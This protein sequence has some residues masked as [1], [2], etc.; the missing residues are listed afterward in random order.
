MAGMT[1]GCFARGAMFAAGL[2][3]V[4]GAI[5][6][7]KVTYQ[8]QVLP[9]IDNHCARCHNPD[10]KKG[11]LDLT[12]YNGALKGGGSGQVLVSGSPDSSKL[13]K[14]I[15]HAE[16]PTMPPNKPPLPD[17][18]IDVFKRWI[19]GGLLENSG[20]KAIAANKS[21]V[22][23]TLKAGAVGKPEGPP[24]MPPELP[25]DP[26]VHTTRAS[27]LTG[28]TCSP[29]APL[30]VIGGQKQVL[31][32]N[33]E[34]LELVGILPDNEGTPAYVQ[35]SRNGKL[36]LVAGGHAAK[37]GRVVLWDI[38]TGERVAT[39]GE[40]YDT[41][42]AADISPDQA[43]VALGGPG[44]LV[45]IYSTTSGELLHKIKKHTDWVTALAFSPNGEYLASADRNGGV[46]IWDPDNGQEMFTLTGHKSAVTAISWRDDSRILASSSEDGTIKWWDSQEGKQAKTWNAH[47]GG[48]LWVSYTHDG[49]LVSCGRDNQ[50]TLWSGEGSKAKS[51]E[52]FGEMPL[53]AALTH[54]GARVVAVD[55]NG[56]AAAWNSADGKRLAE[57]DVNPLP[58]NDRI[59]SAEKR[60]GELRGQGDKPLPAVVE[61]ESKLANA[62]AD[63]EKA[64]KALEQAKA[65]QT[66]KENEVVKLKEIAAKSSPPADIQAK[67]ATAREVRAKAR[68]AFT[69][70]TESLT[71]KTK[72]LDTAKAQLAALK[73]ES[74]AEKI[75]AAQ[76]LLTRLK[77]ARAA[78][79]VFRSR[80]AVATRQREH[81]QLL[82][83]LSARKEE[84][85][86]L[87]Q[88]LGSGDAAAKA[89]LKAQ[90]NTISS[91]VK[92]LEAAVHKTAKD[93]A[94]EEAKLKQ[95]TAEADK[96][97]TA[98][99][100]PVQQSKL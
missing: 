76:A 4:A 32:Y 35:F 57:L 89:K 29:W 38:T 11:D 45:K 80:E 3:V 22:D 79:D 7:E 59:A 65:E 36:L 94:A 85:G 26:L 44:R 2:T 100:G 31:L 87:N 48:V 39:V 60:L 93:L 99:A 15:T 17:K 37:S 63:A 62:N 27:A 97:R 96:I 55:F 5:A 64:N 91:E 88:E 34:T 74:S 1:A 92:K 77:G 24:P 83:E 43:K 73:A 21:A 69:N 56:R 68:E 47:S 30:A 10:K 51:F 86:R 33:T 19:A 40:E 98:S 6:Q 12:S 78:G 20:S 9:L 13:F 46:S 71:A 41:V 90:V 53:R 66:E 50:V 95:L 72:N 14:A 18:E 54:D 28:L 75:A 49:R 23:L 82:A 25:L 52:F 84:L 42:L 58:L 67:L 16:E 70:A 81:K 8:D 61:A